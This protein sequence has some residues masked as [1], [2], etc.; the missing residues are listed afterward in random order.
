MNTPAQIFTGK[1]YRHKETGKQYRILKRE[2]I[3]QVCQPT[4]S[5]T[6]DYVWSISHID[7]GLRYL[8]SEDFLSDNFESIE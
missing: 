5:N 6:S 2:P 4:Q 7:T 1:V 3:N 8:V